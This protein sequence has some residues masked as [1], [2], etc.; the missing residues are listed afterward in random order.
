MLLGNRYELKHLREYWTSYATAASLRSRPV[1]RY[2]S[3]RNGLC[4]TRDGVFIVGVVLLPTDGH[5]CLMEHLVADVRPG[6]VVSEASKHLLFGCMAYAEAI[7]KELYSMNTSKGVKAALRNMG[8]GG[9]IEGME[10]LT[11][12]K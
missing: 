5:I 10:V 2:D 3:A 4:V 6:R 12:W 8:V 11:V 9:V 1:P 7:G